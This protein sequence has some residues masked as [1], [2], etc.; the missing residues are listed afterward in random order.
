MQYAHFAEICD[1]CGNLWNMRELHICIKLTCPDRRRRL[2]EWRERLELEFTGD[3]ANRRQVGQLDVLDTL[4]NVHLFDSGDRPRWRSS[5]TS[6]FSTKQPLHQLHSHRLVHWLNII[7]D[8]NNSLFSTKRTTTTT[9]TTRLTAPF[10]GLRRWAGT[11]TN[12]DFTEAR[13][14]E[15]QWHQLGHM[16]VCTAL[17]TDNHAST[18]PLSFLQA[19]CPSCHPNKSIKGLSTEGVTITNATKKE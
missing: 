1:K 12:L 5:D 9:T 6:L 16:Q 10:P 18:P 8:K 11:K 14:S 2:D 4:R 17:Q 19:G 3:A 7:P 15:W 13:D